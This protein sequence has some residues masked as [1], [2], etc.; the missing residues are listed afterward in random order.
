VEVNSTDSV[1]MMTSTY[2]A[3][4]S[5]FGTTFLDYAGLYYKVSHH[6]R[7]GTFEIDRDKLV[8]RMGFSQDWTRRAVA[9][10]SSAMVFALN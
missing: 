5:G 9:S 7:H 3:V 1:E 4:E 6:R 8:Q 2:N 10:I